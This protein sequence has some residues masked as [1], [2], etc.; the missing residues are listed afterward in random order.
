MQRLLF[1]TLLLA[2]AASTALAAPKL[3]FTREF[4]GS[5]PAYIYVEV[6]PDGKGLY[7]EAPN[8]DYPIAF[9]LQASEVKE[10]QSLASKID[11]C[12]RQLESGLKVANMGMKTLRWEEGTVRNETKF[13]YTQDLD[14]QAL[15]DWFEKIAD[16]AHLYLL[17]ERT[18]KYDKLGVNDSLLKLHAA[19]DRKRIVG[20]NM[21]LPLL[22]RVIKND[23]YM[24]MARERAAVLAESFRA[25]LDGAN[26]GG[27]AQPPAGTANAAA[28]AAKPEA[29]KAPVQAG[30]N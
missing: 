23:T 6:N 28:N 11:N 8:D 30:K 10:M 4:P 24:H 3:V 14:G 5:S 16:S 26:N 1:G 20:V 15:H 13:N 27:G 19:D 18:V 2:A 29:E 7:K 25:R 22:D 12:K 21:Y 9:T 17:L